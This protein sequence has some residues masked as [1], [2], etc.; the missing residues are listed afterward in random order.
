MLEQELQ[1]NDEVLKLAAG[2]VGIAYDHSEFVEA[3]QFSSLQV[4][5]F[6]Q[7]HQDIWQN[8]TPDMQL[9]AS[10]VA[11]VHVH[12]EVDQHTAVGVLNRCRQE[13][14][15]RLTSF[16]DHT[17]GQRIASYRHMARTMGVPPQF[18]SPADVEAYIARKG[19]EKNVWDLVRYKP[20]TQTVEFRMFGA[21]PSIPEIIGYARACLEVVG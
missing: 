7:R 19:G 17:D 12:I 9:A 2:V 21:T 20:S 18:T 11:A 6:D 16:G 13:L 3:C 15:D 5:P 10:A 8:L 14:I 4:N 1:T